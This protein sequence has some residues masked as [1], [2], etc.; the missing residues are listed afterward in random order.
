MMNSPVA[1]LKLCLF[2]LLV[3]ILLPPDLLGP[4]LG[5]NEQLGEEELAAAGGGQ[6]RPSIR[7][8]SAI[9]LEQIGQISHVMNEFVDVLFEKVS[10]LAEIIIQSSL[11]EQCEPLLE[12]D[13]N[14]NNNNNKSLLEQTGRQ[15][16][17]RQFDEKEFTDIDVFLEAYNKQTRMINQQGGCKLFTLEVDS[18]DLPVGDMEICCKAFGACNSVCGNK[19]AA[20]D[21]AFRSCLRSLCKKHFDY[22]NETLIKRQHQ[23]NRRQTHLFPYEPLAEEAAEGMRDDDDQEGLGVGLE[24]PSRPKR[25]GHPAGRKLPGEEEED[26][27]EDDE[28]ANKQTTFSEG[29]VKSLRNKYKACKL[30]S[31]LLIIGNL[32]FGCQAYKENQL[33]ACCGRGASTPGTT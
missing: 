7:L 11:E 3:I 29:T 16:D 33:R 4:P 20:C 1:K 22:A 6:W 15:L 26:D 18:R 28:S 9:Y 21:G 31:K 8:A 30:A 23:L 24:E 17:R 5:R 2:T 14:K 10:F 25:G 27:Q 19:K 32:A 12:C 13:K